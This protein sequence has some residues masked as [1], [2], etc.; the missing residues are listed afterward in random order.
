MEYKVLYLIWQATTAVNSIQ[1][2][3]FYRRSDKFKNK[4]ALPLR[5]KYIIFKK[6]KAQQS[7]LIVGSCYILILDLIHIAYYK[8]Q[9]LH[10]AIFTLNSI[11]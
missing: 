3:H 6:F 9:I 8:M 11:T 5:L 1:Y 7:V 10:S 2:S 4:I